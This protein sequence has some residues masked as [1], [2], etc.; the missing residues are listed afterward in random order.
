[1]QEDKNSISEDPTL[2]VHTYFYFTTYL[3]FDM[4]T[5][6]SQIKTNSLI[7]LQKLEVLVTVKI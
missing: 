6:L 3:L 5:S 7:R 2:L 4:K 1:M